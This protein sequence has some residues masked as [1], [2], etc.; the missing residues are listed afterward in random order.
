M[1]KI[2]FAALAAL[3]ACA[4]ASFAQRPGQPHRLGDVQRFSQQL[5]SQLTA[6]RSSQPRPSL[7]LSTLR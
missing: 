3:L 1:K 2:Y 7:T 5:R 6:A 4:P